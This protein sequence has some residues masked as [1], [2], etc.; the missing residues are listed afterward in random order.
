MAHGAY[1]GLDPLVGASTA[2]ATTLTEAVDA[3]IRARA[4]SGPRMWA[5]AVGPDGPTMSWSALDRA[6]D[7]L[8][9]ALG[10]AGAG[11]G[12]LVAV[13]CDRGPDL[14]TAL[15]AALRSGAAYLPLDLSA[16]P[17][18][19]LDIL[20]EARPAAVLA[21]DAHA[22]RATAADTPLVLVP[23]DGADAAGPPAG[24]EVRRNPT[25]PDDLAYV[26]YTSG[27]TG[28]PKG[29]MVEH[30]AIMNRLAWMQDTFPLGEDDVVLQKTPVTF[31]VSVWEL[32]WPLMTGTPM[33]LAE[34]GRHGDPRHLV[35]TIAARRVTTL[36]FVPTMLGLQ[37]RHRGLLPGT[38]RRV[39][40]SGEALAPGLVSRYVREGNTAEL[41]NLYGPTEAAV[42]VTWWPVPASADL[43]EIPIGRAITGMA[44]EVLDAD[45]EPVPTGTAGEL[46]LSGV[47]LAR[48]YLGRPDLTAERFLRHSRTGVRWYRTGDLA[49]RRPD[50]ALVFLGRLD[51]QVKL[52]GLRIELGEVDAVLTAAPGVAAAATALRDARPGED[53]GDGVDRR[54]L[55]AAV[56]P[57]PHR[58]QVLRDR[59]QRRWAEVFDEGHAE[60][61][62]SGG[63]GYATWTDSVTGE[64]IPAHEMR[65]W[66]D[67]TA[68]RIRSLGPGRVLEVGCGDGLLAEAL[69]DGLDAYVGI[70]PSARALDVARAR[71]ARRD[72]MPGGVEIVLRQGG[73]EDVPRGDLADADCVV[74]NSV[75]QYFPD[76]EYAERFLRRLVA[77]LGHGPGGTATGGP[78]AGRR[79]HVV[80]GDVRD[81]RLWSLHATA[82]E[83]ARAGADTDPGV[84]AA[85]ARTRM[86]GERELLVDPAFFALLPG[87]LPGV[88][89]VQVRPKR[90]GLDN[91]LG[92]YRY[93]VVIAVGDRTGGGTGDPAHGDDPDLTAVEV[94]GHDCRTPSQLREILAGARRRRVTVAGLPDRR[95]AADL[96][97]FL[98]VHGGRWPGTSA[99]AGDETAG[100]WDPEDVLALAAGEG[101][102]AALTRHPDRPAWTFDVTVEPLGADRHAG[103][104]E[105][106]AALAPPRSRPAGSGPLSNAPVVA[107]AVRDLLPELRRVAGQRLP[108]HMV[109]SVFAPVERLPLTSS[110]KA[111]RRVVAALPTLD[112][113]RRAPAPAAPPAGRDAVRALGSDWARVLGVA[114]VGP[115]DHF[116]DLGG[117]SLLAVELTARLSERGVHVPVRFWFDHPVLHEAAGRLPPALPVAA[118]DEPPVP[119]AEGAPVTMPASALQWH[120]LDQLAHTPQ[121]GLYVDHAEFTV[122]GALDVDAFAAAWRYTVQRTPARRVSLHPGPT[123]GAPPV[124]TLHPPGDVPLSVTVLSET[125]D[126]DEATRARVERWLREDRLRGFDRSRPESMR[127]LLVERVAGDTGWFTM[128]LSFDYARVEGWSLRYELDTFAAAYT[129][130]RD[131]GRPGPRPPQPDYREYLPWLASRDRDAARRYFRE[132]L[133]GTRPAVGGVGAPTSTAG[134]VAWA[135]A[136]VPAAEARAA[137]DAARA[138]RLPLSGVL[139]G[140]WARVLCGRG[141][142]LGV[143]V[144]GGEVLF[145]LAVNG[146]SGYGQDLARLSAQL[147]NVLPFRARAAGDRGEVWAEAAARQ[148]QL[149]EHEWAP[150]PLVRSWAGSHP[151]HPLTDTY[152]VIQNLPALTGAAA[153]LFVPPVAGSA[154]VEVPQMEYPLRMTV[155]PYPHG[156]HLGTVFRP[157][158]VAAGTAQRLLHGY[159]EALVSVGRTP[160]AGSR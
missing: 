94:A 9:A 93:D 58:V 39:F 92:R 13:A 149:R 37:L 125:P 79:R 87:R 69:W 147:L 130:Y 110:G 132:M 18:R 133:A 22:A 120:M 54:E 27:S 75:V 106:G 40:A 151:T 19:D 77:G 14:V 96:A 128:Y 112:G 159:V 160:G 123:A 63:P 52:R 156:L 76:L 101:R 74:V 136:W 49:M 85:R 142:P 126:G 141:S 47:G 84:I 98:R 154:P 117:D 24:E 109:P 33:V 36:H 1:G 78:G 129:A 100:A 32:F 12:D 23:G 99:V 21:Q 59:W 115:E 3:G 102:A 17:A 71:A 124:Q 104:E 8:A 150:L 62:G 144:H 114:A 35:E 143:A 157:E 26:L 121:P 72:A 122:R 139:V 16:P 53:A 153:D 38:V 82:V 44:A 137:A 148:L 55:V 11:R 2:S 57:A 155:T 15:V 146:R 83:H 158:L 86:A 5:L 10:R 51:D 61:S 65:R 6:A 31:D 111:D 103:G 60:A 152:L 68:A 28:R 29:V 95:L 30:L 70:D 66:L 20:R 91:E 43:A 56:V 145:G 25:M 67:T 64:P 127:A 135:S 134:P 80:V 41:H 97:T 140:E 90:G 138:L 7:R 50:G 108:H 89:A 73:A 116:V 107:A 34:P 131:G 48:G 46:H 119:E 45:L 42:D 4:S 105:A 118:D 81:L 113:R 88:V